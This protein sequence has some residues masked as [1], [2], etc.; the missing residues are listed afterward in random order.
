MATFRVWNIPFLSQHRVTCPFGYRIWFSYVLIETFDFEILTPG[1]IFW[2]EPSGM[3]LHVEAESICALTTS[4][5]PCESGE[6]VRKISL[7]I[8]Y[9]W[10]MLVSSRSRKLLHLV[11]F[12]RGWLPVVVF[13]DFLCSCKP[14]KSAQSKLDMLIY[15]TLQMHV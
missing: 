13:V 9:Q 5:F 11:Q 3:V 1:N 15:C 10:M 14:E 8:S 2:S 7:P 6:G 12:P 4:S